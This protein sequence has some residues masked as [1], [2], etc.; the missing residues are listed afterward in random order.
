VGAAAKAVELELEDPVRMIERC[1]ARDWVDLAG[2]YRTV[3][4]CHHR[5][6]L[7]PCNLAIARTDLP[8]I[9]SA[10]IRSSSISDHSTERGARLQNWVAGITSALG[11]AIIRLVRLTSIPTKFGRPK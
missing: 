8:L 1:G 6:T 3:F 5:A 4:N 10:M 11:W 9:R 2:T 7:L